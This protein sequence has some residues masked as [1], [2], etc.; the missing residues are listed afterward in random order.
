MARTVAQQRQPASDGPAIGSSAT[1]GVPALVRGVLVIRWAVLV[2]MVVVAVDGAASGD[3]DGVPLATASVIVV[4]GWIIWLTATG[5]P[6][7]TAVLVI[8]LV[9]ACALVVVGTRHVW[10][11]TV[12]PVTAALAWAAARG[13]AGGLVAGGV[14]GAVA[15]VAGLTVRDPAT[16]G[17]LIQVLR[18]PVNFLLAGG[19]LGF[20]ATLLDR[21]AAQV[22]AA[23]AE[24]VRATERAARA[25]ER[26][27]LGRQ[28]HDSVLQAL[29]LV[30]KRG[31]ELA[32]RDRVDGREVGE[33]AD[34]AAAQERVLRAMILRPLDDQP[35][36]AA[37]QPLRDRLEQ[38]ADG[39]ADDPTT[40]VTVVG[41]IR[42]PTL[43]VDEIGA[44]VEQALSNVVRH[45]AAEHAW[46]FAEVDDGELVVSVRD[47]GRGFAFEPHALQAAGKF[48]LLRSIRGRMED[49]GGT[50]HVDA[51]PGRGTELELRIP[52]PEDDPP[53]ARA[54]TTVPG[55]ADRSD[56]DER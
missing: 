39:L 15:V 6:R 19:G 25:T 48:G 7:S 20:V 40:S 17:Q 9:V 53:T 1:S 41:D 27:S 42:L 18:D 46:V 8:D 26:E 10:F 45:A 52:M 36:D 34:L 21:S 56:S 49:L 5:P 14:L 22:R 43:H 54:Q 28:I 23:Q 33:L 37:H 4:A 13:V 30:H 31:R 29:A 44:A 16:S 51:A 55:R 3:V 2:W 35:P 24:Q 50:V 38:I 32:G 12:Y 47:D 11:A